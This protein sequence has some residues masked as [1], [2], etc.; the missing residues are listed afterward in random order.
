VVDHGPVLVFQVAREPPR[1]LRAYAEHTRIWDIPARVS[2][3]REERS[4][5]ALGE[6]TVTL[7]TA[8]LIPI[9]RGRIDVSELF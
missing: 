7:R 1:A 4:L 2:V 8:E 5:R 9:C 3:R 6:L